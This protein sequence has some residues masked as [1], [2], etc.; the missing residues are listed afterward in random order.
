MSRVFSDSHMNELLA[1]LSL[2]TDLANGNPLET[3][4]R[5]CFL[6]VELAKVLKLSSVEMKVV[7]YASLLRSVACTSYSHEEAKI[8]GGDDIAVRSL[9]AP[10]DKTDTLSVL[11][12]T[13]RHLAKNAGTARRI[14]AVATTLTR[15]DHIYKNM[16]AVHCEV[17]GRFVRRLGLSDQI[18]ECLTCNF[19]RWDGKGEPARRKAEEIPLA[20]RIVN[21]AYLAVILEPKLDL[22]TVKSMIRKRAGKQV[23]PHLSQVFDDSADGI[24]LRMK[25]ISVWETVLE[26]AVSYGQITANAELVAEVFAD[27]TDLKSAYT[28]GHSRRVA[29]LACQAASTLGVSGREIER[30]RLAAL[31]HDIGT[32]GI[33]TGVF[34]KRGALNIVER[35]QVE[36]HAYYTQRILGKSSYFAEI[37]ELAGAH[38]EKL[39]GTG[40]PRR[41]SGSAL[42]LPARILVAADIYTALLEERAYRPAYTSAAAA[43]ILHAA[44]KKGEID[45]VVVQAILGL[46]GNTHNRKRSVWPAGLSD[47]EVQVLGL[48][49]RGMSN[50]QIGAD[51][52]ISARTAG[53]HVIHIYN[54]IG[55]STRA[56]AV[57]FAVENDLIKNDT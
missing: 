15:S 44:V 37:A 7:Y 45:G 50:K 42:G 30:L 5:L 18:A 39:N 52:K 14:K 41:T 43:E 32:S 27:F 11:K 36:Q 6:S 26:N 2:A 12:L 49:A 57:L 33:P 55:L 24:F 3:G 31:L 1:S 17:G 23:D 35:E 29:D 19:E 34:E 38:H 47:R 13:V 4:L 16:A 54:K 48:M 46:K 25:N 10:E 56:G 9:Y 51:L 28:G 53:H 22:A 8:F 21:L 40:Y 20:A